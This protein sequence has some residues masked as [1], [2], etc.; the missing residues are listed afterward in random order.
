M[1]EISKK[2]VR[3][4]NVISIVGNGQVPD[5]DKDVDKLYKYLYKNNL[6]GKISSPLIGLFYTEYGGK[7]IVAIPIKEEILITDGITIQELPEVDV[8]SIMHLGSYKT[9]ES[10]FNTLKNYFKEHGLTWKFPVREIY[11][12]SDGDENKF[13]TEIQVPFD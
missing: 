13:K 6:Q 12:K 3:K 2:H 9:I 8:V 7:Y 1:N 11:V 4:I 10:S 5:F